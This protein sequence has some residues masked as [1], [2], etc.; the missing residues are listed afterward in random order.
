MAVREIKIAGFPSLRKRCREIKKIDERIKELAKDLQDT[1]VACDDGIGLASSQ[2]GILRRMFVINMGESGEEPEVIINPEIIS[3][4]GYDIDTEGCLS[5]PDCYGL[6]ERPF[7]IKIKYLDLEGREHEEEAEGLRARCMLHE[8][9]HLNGIMF[10]DR[11]LEGEDYLVDEDKV[12]KHRRFP[13][14]EEI[15]VPE[16][17]LYNYS[18]EDI[19]AYVKRLEAGEA[20]EDLDREKLKAQAESNK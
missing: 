12:F 16:E 17:Y 1:V 20:D 14:F 9:D 2:V 10:L 7:K 5:L 3:Y 11:S 19:D 6:V 13:G 8:L 18:D 15:E 4:E